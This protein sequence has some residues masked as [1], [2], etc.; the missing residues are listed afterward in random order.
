MKR[1]LQSLQMVDKP[2]DRK[3]SEYGHLPW[4]RQAGARDVE[5]KSYFGGRLPGSQAEAARTHHTGPSRQ[6]AFALREYLQETVV[7]ASLWA[8]VPVFQ[9]WSGEGQ[10]RPEGG[11]VPGPPGWPRVL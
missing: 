2:T 1:A 3:L 7:A 8:R 4:R 11:R 10:P 6:K 9:K 5:E